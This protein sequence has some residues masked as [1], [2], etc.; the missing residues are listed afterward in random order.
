M[1][2]L[3]YHVEDGLSFHSLLLFHDL[4]DFV[5]HYKCVV[6]MF[7]NLLLASAEWVFFNL[8]K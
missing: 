1:L 2:I 4:Q 7:L 6:Q 3:V 8:F 5:I